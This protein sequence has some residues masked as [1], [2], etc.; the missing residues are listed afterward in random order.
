MEFYNLQRVMVKIAILAGLVLSS[1]NIYGQTVSADKLHKRIFSIDTHNDTALHINNPNSQARVT[2]GQVTFPL[3]KEG[4]LDAAVFAIYIGQGSRDSASLIAATEYVKDNLLRFRKYVEDYP[5]VSIA[6]CSDDLERNKI[7]GIT[8]VMLAIEN[9][10][11]IGKDISNL[12]RFRDMGVRMMTICHNLNNDICDASMDKGEEHGGL[13]AFGEDVIKEMNRLGIIIDLSHASTKTLFDVVKLSR[14]PVI[15]SHSG[16]YSIKNHNRNLKDEE[17]RAIAAK[18]GLIQIATGRFFLSDLPKD[19]VTVSH[20]AD[21]IDYA[22]KIVGIDHI[23][24][25]TDFDGGGGVVGLENA[26]KMKNLTIELLKR[27]Y[28]EKDLEKFWG[29]N[30]IKFLKVQNL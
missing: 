4:G 1:I 2:K 22:R 28:S 19:S 7:N 24:L 12:E 27:G 13:S 25:G 5:A 20:I 30:F 10:Y 18:G 23:G 29:G 17:M 16:V 15:A 8:S 21:H 11:A 6:Y 9:G 14:K 3:M 26:S